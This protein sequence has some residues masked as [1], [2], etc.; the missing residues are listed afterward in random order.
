[1]CIRDSYDYYLITDNQIPW[2]ADELRENKHSRA[3]LFRMNVA[4]VEK[5]QIPYT[6]ISGTDTQRLENA[7]AVIHALTK[8]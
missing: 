8:L 3:L 5:S 1:M 2:V 4:E 7:I 6:I